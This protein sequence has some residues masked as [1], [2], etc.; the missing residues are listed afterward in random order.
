MPRRVTRHRILRGPLRGRQIVTSWHDYPGGILGYTEKSLLKWFSENVRTGETWLD[1]GAHYGYTAM[2][3]SGL[4]GEKGRVFAFEPVLATA[5]YLSRTRLLNR[6]SQLTVVPFGLGRSQGIG[7]INVPLERGMAE[8]T[9]H[10]GQGEDTIFVVAL[11]EVW[12]T[13]S[14][15][16]PKI[17]GVKIDVQGMEIDVLAGMRKILEAS[18][19]PKLIVELH[20]GVP[21]KVFT[22]LLES[23]GYSPRGLSLTSPAELITYLEDNSSYLFRAPS[24]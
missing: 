17:D 1:V 23:A 12:D 16:R 20:R 11:D 7:P 4:V 3:L 2:A 5:G 22:E 6:L 24:S 9:S 10:T 14:S 21:R 8:H 15:G 19:H 13:L 18:H